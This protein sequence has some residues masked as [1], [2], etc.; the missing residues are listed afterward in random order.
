[1]EG[2]EGT[3]EADGIFGEGFGSA[4]AAGDFDGDGFADL[5]IGTPRED[6]FGA[7][8]CGL[9]QVLFGTAARLSADFDQIFA[10]GD[11][12]VGETRESGDVFGNR[13][14]GSAAVFGPDS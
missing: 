9:M 6:I 2:V 1:M 11:P 10:Q 7:I 8:D 13:L 3:A 4:L 5:A 12:G 14:T